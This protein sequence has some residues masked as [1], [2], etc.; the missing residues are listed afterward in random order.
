MKPFPL[1]FRSFCAAAAFAAAPCAQQPPPSPTDLAIWKDPAF[2]R[3]FTESYLAETDIEPRLDDDDREQM[4]KVMELMANDKLAAAGH[5][6]DQLRNDAK[7]AV[8]DFT[9]ATMHHQAEELPQAMACYLA[10]VEKCPR[11]RRAWRNLGLLY[12]RQA[13]LGKAVPVLTR[14]LE[15]GGTDSATYGLLGFSHASTG[16]PVAAESAYRLANLLDPSAM[17]W[18]MG[19]ARSLFLQKRYADAAAL[20]A[21]MLTANPERADLWQLQANAFLGLEQPRKAAENLEIVDR[22]GQATADSLC[23]LGDIYTN[24]DLPDLAV[25]AYERALAKNPPAKTERAIRAARVLCARGA[26]PQTQQLLAL[27]EKHRGDALTADEKKDVLKLRARLA[28]AAGAGEE[29][30]RVLAEI[31]ALD[32]LDGEALILLGQ[33]AQRS[34]DFEKA[35]FWFER[36][37][38]LEKFEADA[39]VRHAQLLVGQGKY[40]EALPLLRAAQHKQPRDNIQQYLEQVERAAPSR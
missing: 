11:F 35:V 6:L 23:M 5:L 12:V 14:V 29:E 39:K 20:L 24:E 15:L 2:Q 37:Q 16:N 38:S 36:A 4:Q 10:A 28:V 19:L 27:V 32:P 3:R 31:V 30:A 7:N 9:R 17:D 1:A 26:A 22:L 25:G 33:H 13:E 40:A 21:P 34:G 18:R 8:Y